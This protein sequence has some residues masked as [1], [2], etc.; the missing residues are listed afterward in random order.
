VWLFGATEIMKHPLA[1][2][3]DTDRILA[4]AIGN[5]TGWPERTDLSLWE[6]V[7]ELTKRDPWLPLSRPPQPA[8]TV[9][10]EFRHLLDHGPPLPRLQET[11][12]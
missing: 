8:E 11:S 12:A 6:G 2:L 9:L 1:A 7:F 5:A 10:A 3:G 4:E